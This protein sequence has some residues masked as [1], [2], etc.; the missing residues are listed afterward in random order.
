MKTR[1]SV[2]ITPSERL[3]RMLVGALG[4]V[5]GVLLLRGADSGLA[6]ALEALLIVVGFDLLVTGALGHCPLYALL[7]YVRASLKGR[8]H[9][10]RPA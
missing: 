5:G 6:L 4:V 3:A 7:G 10:H 8:T 1:L 9:E 2:N